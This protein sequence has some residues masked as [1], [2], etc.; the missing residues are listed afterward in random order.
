MQDRRRGFVMS[1]RMARTSFDRT[2][3]RVMLLSPRADWLES[4]KRCTTSGVENDR[5][6]RD[7]RYRED[8]RPATYRRRR[9]SHRCLLAVCSDVY[10]L[11]KC[12]SR[13][14]EVRRTPHVRRVVLELRGRMRRHGPSSFSAGPLGPARHP[15]LASGLRPRMREQRGRVRSPRPPSPSLRDLRG[16]LQGL[17]QGVRRVARSSDGSTSRKERPGG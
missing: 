3:Q 16:G 13:G 2:G 5:H 17:R 1:S 9:V 8:S 7:A 14:R 10:Y 6:Q 15:A 4:P 12:R 11:R